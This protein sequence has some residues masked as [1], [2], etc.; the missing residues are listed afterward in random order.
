[1]SLFKTRIFWRTDCENEEE[2]FD[3]N[4][5][6]IT[7]LNDLYDFIVTGSHSGILRIFQP[8]FNE[9]TDLSEYKPSDLLIEKILSQPILQVSTGK[10]VS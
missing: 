3:Q 2:C 4:S 1:M 10:L 9:I 8:A 5:L 6:T 7:K